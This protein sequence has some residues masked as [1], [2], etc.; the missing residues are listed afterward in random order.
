[1]TAKVTVG[2]R[3]CARRG[4]RRAPSDRW[5]FLSI[6]VCT[7]LLAGGSARAQEGRD[8]CGNVCSGGECLV[9]NLLNVPIGKAGLRINDACQLEVGRVGDTREDGVNILPRAPEPYWLLSFVGPNSSNPDVDWLMSFDGTPAGARIPLPF[10]VRVISDSGASALQLTPDF[11]GVQAAGV[12]VRLLR[13]GESVGGAVLS[14]DPVKVG[15]GVDIST[16]VARI[17]ARTTSGL[18]SPVVVEVGL[19]EPAPVDPGDGSTAEA[20]T[21]VFLAVE[22]EVPPAA[23]LEARV[24]FVGIEPLVIDFEYAGPSGSGQCIDND[25]DGYGAEGDPSCPN[26]PQ[27]DCDDE[28]RDVNPGAPEV[29]DSRDNDC[30]GCVDEGFDEDGDTFTTCNGDCDDTNSLINPQAPERCNGE[31]DN[32]N[33][34]VDE[35][36]GIEGVDQTTYEV[37]TLPIGAVC[38]TGQGECEVVGVV[39]CTPDGTAAFCDATPLPPGVEGPTGA[40]NCF[41]FRDN[42]CDGRIDH[43]DPDCVGPEV[44]DGFDNDGD[45]AID[46]DFQVLGQPCAVGLGLCRAQ[47]RFV[48]DDAGDAVVCNA[49]PNEPRPEGPPGSRSCS[50]GIDDDCDRLVDKRDP[51]CCG[52]ERC[53]GKDNDC[54][55]LI[56][57]DFA[58]LLGTECSAGLGAC[59]RYGVYVCDVDGDVR[60]NAVPLPGD[61]E[62][63]GDCS[64][65][66]GIDNDCDLLIDEEDPD[67]ISDSLLPSCALVECRPMK[68]PDC[69]SGHRIS[70][71]SNNVGPAGDL[72]AELWALDLNG[73]IRETIPVEDGDLALLRSDTTGVSTSTTDLTL[74]LATFA[75]WSE[76]ETGPENG[77]YNEGCEVFDSDCDGDIDLA[78]AAG[79]QLRFGDTETVHR[80]FA[81][82]ILLHTEV[83]N[84][85][86]RQHAFCSNMPYMQVIEPQETVV[87]ESEGDITRVLAAATRIRP[88]SIKILV[89]GVDILPLIGVQPVFDFPG[90]PYNG[91]YQVVDANGSVINTVEVCD[92][93]VRSGEPGQNSVSMILKNLG[94]GGHLIAIRGV[95]IPGSFPDPADPTCNVDDLVD[96]GVSHGLGIDLTDPEPGQVVASPPVLVQG[97]ACHGRE[98]SD[99]L[100]AGASIFP[101]PQSFIPG[102]GVTTADTWRVP[103]E[104]LVDLNDI[105]AEADGAPGTP[106]RLDPGMNRLVVQAVDAAG[107]S[108]VDER[109]VAVGPVVEVPSVTVDGFSDQLEAIAANIAATEVTNAFTL[110]MDKDTVTTFFA[111]VCDEV[112]PD[113]ASKLEERLVG[114]ESEG[115]TVSAPFPLCDPKNVRLKVNSINIDPNGLA[116]E[117][118]PLTDKVRLKLTLPSFTASTKIRGGCKTTCCFGIC[119]VRVTVDTNADWEVPSVSVTFEITESGILN[120]DLMN[121]IAFDTGADPIVIEGSINDNTDVGCIVGALLD[122]L[123]FLLEVITLGFWDPGFDDVEFE[124]KGD[125]LKE[126]IGEDGGDLRGIEA[127]AIENEDLVPEFGV[128]LMQELGDVQI[129]PNGLAASIDATFEVINVD[130]NAADI[131]GTPLTP[132]PLPLPIIPDS[133]GVTVG[134]SD[135]VFNQLLAALTRTGTLSTLFEE[136]KVLGDFLPDPDVCDTLPTLVEPRCVGITGGNCDQFILPGRRETCEETKQKWEERLLVPGTAVILRGGV[137]VPPKIFID[138]DPATTDEVEVL[139]RYSQVEIGIFADRDG[140]GNLDGPLSTIPGCFGAT[141]STVD[142]CT[143]WGACLNVDVRAGLFLPPG[144]LLLRMNVLDVSHELSTGTLCGGGQDDLETDLI[145][146]AAGS[147]TLDKLNERLRQGTPDL[148]ANG[149]DFGGLVSFENARLI[150]IENDGAPDFQDYI[151]ITGDLVVT[152]E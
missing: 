75:K 33:E 98:I 116:C 130:P 36:F 109:I 58:E 140:D 82:A 121:D 5:R 37:T 67:C 17:P 112:G 83:D 86:H 63:P 11:S 66:D 15:A 80:M 44:C 39:A 72:T 7:L 88:S 46:E 19:S 123:D 32:C 87:S 69:Y 107:N 96:R 133:E 29:C 147:Q 81:P 41:D 111:E 59:R 45:G 90:G 137:Q 134:I 74:G 21:V 115:K 129:S 92:L 95:E 125:D 124:L 142:E 73:K 119:V 76:C 136:V 97:Y 141:T 20:T 52:A 53:D 151:A 18:A 143:L 1:M 139:M 24:A 6:G 25:R 55:D 100:I 118:T 23:I 3:S 50:N 131:P 57:E 79:Y 2:A 26:G 9:N 126:K 61:Y 108:T 105:R 152:G 85:F 49:Q 8:C 102:D 38:V 120:Q 91:T 70:L 99:V 71:S 117:V 145:E 104:N 138:D 114:F 122:I 148:K 135:D 28:R 68:D 51:D 113:V 14:G 65:S 77:P 35:G 128:S 110:A 106:G 12:E 42:D 60:C 30:D 89:D 13:D 31:D 34:R 40:D 10:W 149:L 146:G 127:V 150:A 48:C 16:V 78:D 84:G 64:C 27:P 62:G 22:V 132:A 54:D 144:E 103:L 101:W 93:Y 94:C 4:A 47:G 56:D 43:E